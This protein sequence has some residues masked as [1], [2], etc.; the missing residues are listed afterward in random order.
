MTPIHTPPEKNN[1]RKVGYTLSVAQ[2]KIPLVRTFSVNELGIFYDCNI[3]FH[4]TRTSYVIICIHTY[5]YNIKWIQ[6][7]LFVIHLFVYWCVLHIYIPYKRKWWWY[8]YC[9]VCGEQRS[10]FASF[11]LYLLSD[12]LSI[13]IVYYTTPELGYG[14]CG[15]V[16]LRIRQIVYTC[17]IY[18][19]AGYN[20]MEKQVKKS[21][22]L[23]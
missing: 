23:T 16:A 12:S 5:I 1:I 11:H 6:N 18:S 8:L 2:K 15:I 3:N 17:G 4:H 19:Y 13:C 21:K 20:N 7:P 22:I 14:F 9:D 10:F